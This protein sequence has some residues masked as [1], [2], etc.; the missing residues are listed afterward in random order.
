MLEKFSTLLGKELREVDSTFR[1][2]GEEFIVLLPHT[3]REAARGVAE[4]PTSLTI[5]VG[6]I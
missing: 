2:G 6:R 3:D 5:P 4:E 1:Y